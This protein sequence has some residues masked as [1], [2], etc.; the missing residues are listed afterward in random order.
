MRHRNLFVCSLRYICKKKT[1][2]LRG[3][4]VLQH[5]LLSLGKRNVRVLWWMTK[6][7]LMM[8]Y[9]IYLHC[10]DHKFSIKK[11]YLKIVRV[12]FLC[13]SHSMSGA[14]LLCTN[15]CAC[16]CVD[17]SVG[18]CTCTFMWMWV[19]CGEVRHRTG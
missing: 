12:L 10:L 16:V 1:T 11:T 7:V 3:I 15:L 17:V 19:C 8:W 18:V 2:V 13:I 4:I 6:K 5:S 14:L 9:C